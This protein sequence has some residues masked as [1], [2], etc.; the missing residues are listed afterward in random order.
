MLCYNTVDP[1]TLDLLKKLQMAD[2][3]KKMRL[4]G[5]TSLALQYGHR[6]SIDLDL[7]G[8]LEMSSEELI[9]VLK[10]I[11]QVQ[12][13][14]D[15][16]RIHTYSINGV[17]TDIVEY[18]YPWI[19]ESIQHDSFI[20]ASDIDIA[21]MKLNAVSGRGTKKDFIDVYFLLKRM[22]LTTM[23]RHFEKKYEDGSTYLVL[24]SLTYFEDAEDDLDPVMLVP[25]KWDDVKRVI[26]AAVNEYVKEG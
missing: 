18:S 3:F 9:D 17:K 19:D 24:R 12:V 20:L 2:E 13:I 11:G 6:K 4:A 26:N 14:K 21:A 15:S 7:F 23:I 25:C 22:S 8:E 1:A 10:N 16:R 5:G